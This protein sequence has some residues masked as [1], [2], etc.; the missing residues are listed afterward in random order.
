MFTNETRGAKIN[1]F[2]KITNFL[3]TTV[4]GAADEENVLRFQITVY[5]SRLPNV[6]EAVQDGGHESSDPISRQALVLL[7][8][9]QIVEGTTEQFEAKAHVLTKHEVFDQP[10]DGEVVPRALRIGIQLS[11]QL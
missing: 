4:R 7:V 1:D 3:G 2:D 9:D 6:G 11:K 5:N 10:D 8:L